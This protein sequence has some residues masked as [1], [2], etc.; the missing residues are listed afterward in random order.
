M[1]G[2]RFEMAHTMILDEEQHGSFKIVMRGPQDGD[3][4]ALASLMG[5]Y[6]TQQF[7]LMRGTKTVKDE[8]EWLEKVRTNNDEVSWL[9]S[10]VMADKETL[11]GTTHLRTVDDY[12]LA[13]GILLADQDWWGKGI[14]TLTHKFR[15]W[16]AFREMGAYSIESNF[17]WDNLASGKA[18]EKV[19]YVRCGVLPRYRLIAGEWRD[20]V[21]MICHN[22]VSKDLL[23]PGSS[24]PDSKIIRGMKQTQQ[25][26][27]DI[28]GLIQHR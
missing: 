21:L 7:M 4:E 6:T 15:T 2:P 3:A 28:D 23:W 10:V 11:I 27:E 22:P 8:E 18:L 17:I 1:F 12:R 5:S 19:G 14:A 20:Q 25:V 16:Y 13:S 9:I 26:L 24:S